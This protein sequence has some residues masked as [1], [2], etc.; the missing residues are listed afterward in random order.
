MMDQQ[1]N[2]TAFILSGGSSSRMGENKALLKINGM[3]QIQRLLEILNPI[4]DNIII[5]SNDIQ[6]FKFTGK[7]VI[8]DI[9][10]GQGPL[11]AIHAGLTETETENNFFISCDMPFIS[12]EMIKY[13]IH[14]KSNALIV[15][16]KVEG[17]IQQ[18][19]G[20]YSKSILPNV[21]AHLLEAQKNKSTVKGSIFELLGIVTNETVEVSKLKIYN[22]EIFFNMN[23]PNDYEY[24]KRK[25]SKN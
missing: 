25:Y 8:K 5:S 6:Q 18:L 1:K 13:L 19:C 24:V 22:K 10:S 23:T 20:M 14:Y 15:L 12:T 2:I 21:E 9:Y 11:A 16:P 7:K 17:K 3:Y 4:F